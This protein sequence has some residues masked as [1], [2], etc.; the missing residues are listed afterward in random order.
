[1]FALST[2]VDTHYRE[3]L[4]FI[5][6]ILFYGFMIAVVE[7]LWLV[8]TV[9]VR[10]GQLLTFFKVF[11]GLTLIFRL[12]IAFFCLSATFMI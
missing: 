4:I 12:L 9:R 10:L 5:T 2:F 1:M 11:S 6:F 3:S 8:V 7:F